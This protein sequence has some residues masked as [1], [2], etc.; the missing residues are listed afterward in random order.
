MDFAED[1]LCK[2][3]AGMMEDGLSDSHKSKGTMAERVG[4]EPTV[5]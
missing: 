1:L 3:G 5:V 2:C 4:F